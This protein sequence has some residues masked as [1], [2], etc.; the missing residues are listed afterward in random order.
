M[1]LKDILENIDGP[2]FKCWFNEK[3]RKGIKEYA[4]LCKKQNGRKLCGYHLN[5]PVYS[6]VLATG[7]LDYSGV[8][9]ENLTITQL[10]ELC[11]MKK[12]ILGPN[13]RGDG[14][15][16]MDKITISQKRHKE[17]LKD[18]LKE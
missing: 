16:I 18:F 6:S 3:D 17:M 9:A 13:V 10:N 7:E 5:F 12:K 4:L 1:N 2:L 8:E 15:D 11:E 14:W